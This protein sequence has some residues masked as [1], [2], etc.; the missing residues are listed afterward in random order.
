MKLSC[1]FGHRWIGCKCLNCAKVRNE[2]HDWD[3]QNGKCLMCGAV[4]PSQKTAD[5][6][7]KAAV[8]PVVSKQPRSEIQMLQLPFSWD[9]TSHTSMMLDI[10]NDEVVI[11]RWKHIPIPDIQEVLVY[12]IQQDMRGLGGCIKFVTAENPGLPELRDYKWFVDSD[13]EIEWEGFDV[14]RGNCLWYG[15]EYD[16][17]GWILANQVAEQI[18]FTV[19]TLCSQRK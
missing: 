6:T 8:V 10:N 7:K 3:P 16:P 14:S 19:E 18:K 13:D 9:Q 17:D 15:C 11:C 2:E 5:Q 12:P 4:D 1:I